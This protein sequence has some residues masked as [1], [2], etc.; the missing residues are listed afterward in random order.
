MGVVVHDY[1]SSY[2]L[3]KITNSYFYCWWLSL[4]FSQFATVIYGVGWW[5]GGWVGWQRVS[6]A[7]LSIIHTIKK[8][9]KNIYFSNIYASNRWYRCVENVLCFI[10]HIIQTNV[11]PYRNQNLNFNNLQDNT[12]LRYNTYKYILA[13]TL[14]TIKAYLST[15]S[16]KKHASTFTRVKGNVWSWKSVRSQ[17]RRGYPN[18]QVAD[19][20]TPI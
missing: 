8:H 14:I 16:R 5:V 10:D 3:Q 12:K 13:N 1:H 4:L 2:S 19:T 9:R 20:P 6:R 15:R 7:S 17:K 11:Y 18:K